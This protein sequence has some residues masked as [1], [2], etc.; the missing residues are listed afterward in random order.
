MNNKSQNINKF[1]RRYE[2]DETITIWKYDLNKSTGPVEVNISYKNNIDKKWE[3][4]AKQ[5][6][7][8]RRIERQM[9]KINNKNTVNKTGKRGRPKKK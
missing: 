6:Q 9:R 3:K 8:E 2:D 4:R 1:E 7:D 5:A